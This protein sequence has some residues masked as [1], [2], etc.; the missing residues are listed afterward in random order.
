MK[1]RIT[2]FF[3]FFLLSLAGM[4]TAVAQGF[5]VYKSDGTVAQ[6]SFRTDSIVFYD[7]IGSDADFGPFTPVNDLIVGT[8]YRT[9]KEWITFNADGTTSGWDNAWNQGENGDFAY[10][11]FPYQGN[12]VIYDRTTNRPSDYIRVLDRDNERMVT[13]PR[14]RDGEEIQVLTRAV[15]PQLVESIWF[16]TSEY[17]L[18]VGETTTLSANVYPEDAANREVTWESTNEYIATVSSDGS[19]T[20]V[21]EGNCWIYCFATDG[22]GV[23]GYCHVTVSTFM[24]VSRIELNRSALNLEACETFRL[25]PT[26]YPQNA[27]N[28]NVTWATSNESVASVDENGVVT[29]NGDG[30]CLIICTAADGS[31]VSTNCQIT[32]VFPEYVEIGGLKWATKNVGATTVAGSYETCYGDYFAWSETSPRYSNIMRTSASEATITMKSSYPSG[33]SVSHYVSYSEA[34]LDAS[35]DAATRNLG[36]NWFTPSKDEFTALAEACGSTW[37]TLTGKVTEGGIYTLSETQTYEPGYTGVAG[38]LF[39]STSDITKRVF[40]PKAGYITGTDF[41]GGGTSGSYWTST[42]YTSTGKA[43]YYSITGGLYTDTRAYGHTV[44]AVSR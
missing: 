21:N 41:Y 4:Q 18:L 3:A 44:R 13:I 20:A 19:V 11:F 8:W 23:F 28:K 15:P 24:P 30:S 42:L 25:T 32:S 35:H 12:I 16:D 10:R 34:T 39:V 2:F 9:N 7:G 29:A 38:I 36:S 40:F 6:F 31:G 33:Y 22:S 5:R 26:V 37:K 17:N 14:S 27:T 1:K 43:Y